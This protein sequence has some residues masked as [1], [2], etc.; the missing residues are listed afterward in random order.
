M[1]T[2][3]RFLLFASFAVMLVGWACSEAESESLPAYPKSGPTYLSSG[4]LDVPLTFE[5]LVAE[6]DLIAVVEP[7]AKVDEVWN[8]TETF[9]SSRFSARVVEVL[10]GEVEPASEI[11]LYAPGGQVRDPFEATTSRR[12]VEDAPS[13]V[14][15]YVDWPFF[16]PKQQ[17]FL[18]LKLV[19]PPADS[20]VKP[21]YWNLGPSARYAIDDGRIESIYPVG[22][23]VEDYGGVRARLAGL[24]LEEV[25]AMIAATGLD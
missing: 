12:P 8:V 3:P 6:A 13:S 2:H 22:V 17:E 10:K 16:I 7:V 25:A 14:D 24:R 5:G 4:H 21:F 15:E 20:N 23:D 1:K 19:T 9:V 11:L 18:F